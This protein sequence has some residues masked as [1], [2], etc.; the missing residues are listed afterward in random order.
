MTGA[1]FRLATV[2]DEDLLIELMEE[3]YRVEHLPFEETI[4]RRALK[5]ILD[6]TLFGLIHLIGAED[7]VAGYIVLTFGFSLE[8]HGRDA[9]VDELY[10]R[11]EFR[12]RGLG[13]AALEFIEGVCRNE[14]IEAIHLEVDRINVRA[15]EIY[16]R[17]GYRDHD[18][19]L[20][21]KWL[22]IGDQFNQQ[23]NEKHR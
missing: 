12:R 20:L 6:N 2:D 18:R 22:D 10:L 13:R 14:G 4:A 3:F 11:E 23:P 17:A 21:T 15:Q 19:Y 9:L 16:R 5:Q 8:F 1:S 7:A